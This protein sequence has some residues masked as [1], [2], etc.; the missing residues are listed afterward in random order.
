LAAV[1]FRLNSM[2]EASVVEQQAGESPAT[3]QVAKRHRSLFRGYLYTRLRAYISLYVRPTDR[4]LEIPPNESAKS[5]SIKTDRTLVLSPPALE[6]E[7]GYI[8]ERLVEFQPDYVLLHGNVH[9]ER[10]VQGFLEKLR[11]GLPASARIIL[12]YYST[13]WKPLLRLATALGLRQKTPEENWIANEDIWNLLLLAE[14]ELVRHESK[15]LIPLYIPLVSYLI[16]RFLSPLPGFSFFN[17]V[18]VAVA[19]PLKSAQRSHDK[20]SVSVIIPARNEAGNIEAAI[21]RT[22][23]MGPNDELIF[24]EGNSTDD[25]WETLCRLKTQYATTRSIQLARQSGKGKGDAVR[26]GFAVAANE[27]LM[28]LDADLTVA[29]E[30][31]PRFYDAITSGK[32]EFI[33]GSRLVYPMEREAMRFF[34]LLGNKFFAILFSFVLGQRFKDTLCGTKVLTRNNYERLAAHRQFFGEFDP[35]GDFDLIFG[36][37]RM[38]LRVVEVP[39]HYRERTYGDTNIHR[40]RHGVVL[41]RMLF[42]AASRIKFL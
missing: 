21:L 32:G 19:R 9:Y 11:P 37:A 2:R 39:V 16:N 36:A 18:N 8:A 12:V 26:K 4:L 15:I 28:I 14:Y 30:E 17:L 13:L 24:V 34:N 20:P 25:T 7:A 31:L 29:P 5:L 41:L 10:D 22:P 6:V 38:A 35:F 40:W 1:F 27:I 23:I 33:N 42:F 3:S